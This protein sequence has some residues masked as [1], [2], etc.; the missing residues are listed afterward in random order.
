MTRLAI[1]V[2]ISFFCL[3][4]AAHKDPF[5]GR[6]KVTITPDDMSAAKEFDDVF[7]FDPGFKF[8]VKSLESRG[9]KPAEYEQDVRAVGPAKF[10]ATLVSDSDG[11]MDWQGTAAANEMRGTMTWTKKD[12]TQLTYSFHGSRETH[13]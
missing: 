3:A 2:L 11:K 13:R 4:A 1:A 7:F 12:G 10:T 6:W 8:R 9:Y 5:A